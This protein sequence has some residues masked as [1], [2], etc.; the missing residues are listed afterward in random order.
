M[1]FRPC[2]ESTI[3]HASKVE[4]TGPNDK[5]AEGDVASGGMNQNGHGITQPG[6]QQRPRNVPNAYMFPNQQFP[7]RQFPN[8]PFLNQQFPNR[9]YHKPKERPKGTHVF[10]L[11]GPVI[12]KS[13]KFANLEIGIL[14][15]DVI[16][17]LFVFNQDLLI[18]DKEFEI[19][20][21]VD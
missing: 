10:L 5:R 15:K 8:Q 3:S 6:D 7:N 14:S 12:R 11:D 19:W 4:S 20:Q 2:D 13:F 18:T 16:I 17:K 21:V 9:S 1:S